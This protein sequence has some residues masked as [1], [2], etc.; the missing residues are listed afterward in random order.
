M[1]SGQRRLSTA[2]SERGDELVFAVAETAVGDDGPADCADWL[3]GSLWAPGLTLSSPW[4]SETDWG[5][6]GWTGV[7]AR[8]ASLISESAIRSLAAG[9][10]TPGMR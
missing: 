3:P 6:V 10:N 2:G 7:Y 9:S 5:R 1:G 4:A 8:S